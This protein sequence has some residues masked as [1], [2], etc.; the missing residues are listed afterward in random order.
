MSSWYDKYNRSWPHVFVGEYGAANGPVRTVQA[1]VGEAL[2]LLGLE[3]NSD[4]VRAAS[5]APL[6]ANVNGNASQACCGNQ[7]NL[8]QLNATAVYALPS[9]YAQVMLR[10][11][12][13]TESFNTFVA[14]GAVGTLGAQASWVVARNSTSS[15]SSSSQVGATST[16][17][18]TVKLVNYH[19]AEQAVLIDL[20]PS[21]GVLKKGSTVPATVLSNDNPLAENTLEDPTRVVPRIFEGSITVAAD[22]TS[23]TVPMPPWSLMVLELN[24]DN[25][26]E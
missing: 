3:R 26:R 24:A 13:G 19:S 4:V 18:L 22:G 17:P 9:F 11:A 1:A 5:F 25:H 23:V 14:G 10:D 6:L 8:L 20:D 2:F 16:Q 12:L 7:H 15:S 21:F